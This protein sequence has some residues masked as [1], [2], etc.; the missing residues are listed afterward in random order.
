MENWRIDS[1]AQAVLDYMTAMETTP[2]DRLSPKEARLNKMLELAHGPEQFQ[3]R[4]LAIPGPEN[5]IQLRIYDPYEGKQK[6]VLVW[7]HGGGWVLGD[8]DMEDGTCRRLASRT[9]CIVVSVAYRLAPEAKYPAAVEDC[10]AATCWVAANGH[11]VGG[12]TNLL[13]VGGDSVGGTLA[14]AVCLMARDRNGP[15]IKHQLMVCP[16]MDRDFTTAT[17]LEFGDLFRPTTRLMKWF[18][19]H[20]LG[21]EGDA[22]EPYAAPLRAVDVSM[23]PSATIIT[24]EFDVLRDEGEAYGARLHEAGVPVSVTRCDGTIHFLLLLADRIQKGQEAINKIAL[25]LE[26]AFTGDV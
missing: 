26:R 11:T 9:G 10:F 20:Y 6:P 16:V 14:A 4:D 1:E 19:K 13:A 22:A 17:Y 3:V 2:L 25:D 24:A 15:T 7:F 12:N 8:L 23:L 21:D 5:V 18:W